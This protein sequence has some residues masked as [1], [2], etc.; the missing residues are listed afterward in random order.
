MEN[1]YGSK[2]NWE[3]CFREC[4]IPQIRPST[5]SSALAI[6]ISSPMAV[7]L[8]VSLTHS[9]IRFYF[10]TRSFTPKPS[11][12]LHAELPILSSAIIS[13][14]SERLAI[15]NPTVS[16]A[17]ISK[18]WH[19]WRL[20]DRSIRAKTTRF[21]ANPNFSTH[22]SIYL[23]AVQPVICQNLSWPADD[24]MELDGLNYCAKCVLAA[25]TSAC[26]LLVLH[27]FLFVLQNEREIMR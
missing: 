18:N 14:Y 1:V 27:L 24:E 10:H 20:S 15:L 26:V 4:K 13:V 2:C 11:K 22:N 17:T 25:S 23:S 8:S 21:R 9:S 7:L 12:E 16:L 6:S 19:S 3:Y 5:A